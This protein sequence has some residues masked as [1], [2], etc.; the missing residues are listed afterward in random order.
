[1]SKPS[2]LNSTT[3]SLATYLGTQQTQSARI[4]PTMLLSQQHPDSCMILLVTTWVIPDEAG[5]TDHRK[6]IPGRSHV[7]NLDGTLILMRR[8]DGDKALE[9]KL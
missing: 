4:L 1:M 9:N 5:S 6:Q 3:F 2:L 8:G 7:H